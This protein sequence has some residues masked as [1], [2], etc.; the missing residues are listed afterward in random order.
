MKRDSTRAYRNLIEE[1]YKEKLGTKLTLEEILR[2]K[3]YNENYSMR[4]IAD[5]FSLSVSTVHGWFKLYNIA[6]R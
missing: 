5:R 3:Y 6:T 4:D 1:L 2:Y